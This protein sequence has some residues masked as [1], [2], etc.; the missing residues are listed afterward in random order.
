LNT[1][2]TLTHEEEK[3]RLLAALNPLPPMQRDA[4][5]MNALEGYDIPDEARILNEM[6]EEMERAIDHAREK[7]KHILGF[8]ASK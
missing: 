8:H 6:P 1:L 4:K 2:S 7:L 3:Q 5:S